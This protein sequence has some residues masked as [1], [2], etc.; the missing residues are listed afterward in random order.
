[1][2]LIIVQEMVSIGEQLIKVKGGIIEDSRWV[3]I[4]A[5]L[6]CNIIL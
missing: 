1:M 5:L 4:E 6:K 3:T 2:I